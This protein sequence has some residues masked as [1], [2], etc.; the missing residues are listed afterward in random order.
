MSTKKKYELDFQIEEEF[1]LFGL[2]AGTKSFTLAWH[3]NSLL[4]IK[5]KKF[6]DIEFFMKNGSSFFV[7]NFCFVTEHITYRLLKNKGYVKDE[8]LVPFL[9]PE[10]NKYDFFLHIHGEIDLID[11]QK[12]LNI[13]KYSDFLSYSSFVETTKLKSKNNFVTLH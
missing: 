3:L 1:L 7:S 9:V 13:L 6:D 4:Q 10:M 5:L 2:V 8:K 11:K 12:V